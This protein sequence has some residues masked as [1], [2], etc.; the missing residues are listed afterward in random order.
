M[1]V[2]NLTNHSIIHSSISPLTLLHKEKVTEVDGD[3]GPILG[4]AQ[5]ISHLDC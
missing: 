5:K 4:Q 2:N 3:I 1:I